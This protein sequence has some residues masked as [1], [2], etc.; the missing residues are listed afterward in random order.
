M[1]LVEFDKAGAEW[2]VVA[3]ASGDARMI[4]VMQ[5]TESPHVITGKLISGA[6]A[7]LIKREDEFLQHM[8]DPD[9]LMRGRAKH[10][11]ELLDG[12]YFLPRS[13][14]I[15]Q[16]GKKSNHGLNYRMKYRRFALETGLAEADARTIVE[17]YLTQAY[18]NIP[19]WWSLIERQLEKGRALTNCFG[20]KRVFYGQWGVELFEQ[21]TA[22]IPQSTI[23]DVVH[24]ATIAYWDA[25]NEVCLNK[26]ELLA[27][28]GD[29][30]LMQWTAPERLMHLVLAAQEIALDFLNPLMEY[31]GR[32]F[33]IRTDVTIGQSWG[34]MIPWK[35]TESLE[36][37]QTSLNEALEMLHGTQKAS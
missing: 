25:R 13:M 23:A 1:Y 26:I 17:S 33:R 2:A 29:S 28:S 6:P 19:V 7:D 4:E 21:A 10:V 32:E 12:E 36:E 30:L 3:Y 11:P 18:P 8:T 9:E 27:Q 20:R 22:F 34:H 5:G 37:T 15:R 35:V 16:A 24:R 31:G 14:T